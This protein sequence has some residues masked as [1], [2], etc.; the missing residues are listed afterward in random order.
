MSR[1][2]DGVPVSESAYAFQAELLCEDC[3]RAAVKELRSKGVAD[4]GDSGTFPQGPYPDGGGEAD[5]AQ[6]C[7]RGRHCLNAV[8]VDGHRVGCPLS[9]YLTKDGVDAVFESVKRGLASP[10]KFEQKVGRLLNHVWGANFDGR[11]GRVLL[12]ASLPSLE[13]LVGKTYVLHHVVLADPGNLYVLGIRAPGQT[14]HLLR[15]GVDD[16]GKFASL[17]VVDVP[18]EILRAEGVQAG[19]RKVVELSGVERLLRDAAEDGA[20]D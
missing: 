8:E 16:E 9:C 7:G 18:A 1:W 10:R 2:L 4:D 13:R 20:W 6:F 19:Q 11:I 3:G 15:A 17:D 5:S 14:Y 12:P